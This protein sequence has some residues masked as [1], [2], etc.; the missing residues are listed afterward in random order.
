MWALTVL[1]SQGTGS[2]ADT[3]GHCSSEKSTETW[4]HMWGGWSRSCCGHL[5]SWEERGLL[6]DHPHLAE[7]ARVIEAVADGVVILFP[8]GTL[9]RQQHVHRVQ[10]VQTPGVERRTRWGS[11]WET[12]A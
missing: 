10:S 3:H 9:G 12:E 4:A 7:A 6:Q 1:P 5:S 2:G 8:A 11:V